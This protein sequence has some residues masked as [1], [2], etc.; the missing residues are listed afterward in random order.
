LAPIGSPT[1][2][3]EFDSGEFSRMRLSG[4]GGVD[5]LVNGTT[6][7]AELLGG[8][9]ND[10]LMGGGGDD[11]LAGQHGNDV[12]LFSTSFFTGLGHDTVQEDNF[13]GIDELNFSAFDRGVRVD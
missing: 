12:Y 8:A 11:L 6:I 5:V 9:G 7:N 2:D 1:L 4:L 10:F 3:R 13:E